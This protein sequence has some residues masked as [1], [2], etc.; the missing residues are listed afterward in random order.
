MNRRNIVILS[1]IT[2]LGLALPPSSSVA[3]QGSLRQQLVG[4]WTLVSCDPPANA[5]RQPFCVNPSG[6][7]NLDANGRYTLVIEAR[8]RPKVTVTGPVNRA[9]LSPEEY[10]AIAQG[11][12]AQ[13]GTWSVNEADKTL[14]QHVE[15]AFIP[16]N[17]GNDA[18]LSVSLTGDELKLVAAIGA[19]TWRRS[20]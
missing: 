17:E 6:S 12:A 8:G 13:F 11:V 19:F 9:T 1:A 16:N 3:Q 5:T 15:G 20:K 10:K 2:V 18:K 4:T 7:Y 14:T